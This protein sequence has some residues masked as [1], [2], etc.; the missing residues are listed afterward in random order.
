M[1][2]RDQQSPPRA[3]RTDEVRPDE[4][5]VRC[6]IDLSGHGNIDET[7]VDAIR[8]QVAALVTACADQGIILHGGFLP[9][10]D[11]PVPPP[12]DVLAT[13]PAPSPELVGKTW[14]QHD[15]EQREARDKRA[16]DLE[17]EVERREREI[18]ERPRPTPTP[19]P[20]E[21]PAP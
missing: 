4:V 16:K 13:L 9:L 14:A 2:L 19:L 3:T 6:Q 5:M 20:A 18:R 8:G 1:A 12:E 15:R 11:E 10:L 7:K 21:K 17:R